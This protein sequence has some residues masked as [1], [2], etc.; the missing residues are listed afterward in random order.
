MIR[1]RHVATP[2]GVRID[3]LGAQD[4]PLYSEYLPNSLAEPA[5]NARVTNYWR[6]L[7]IGSAGLWLMVV[8]AGAFY[9]YLQ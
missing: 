7:A 1:T 8:I 4:E 5:T 6:R 3:Y 2:F 9:F